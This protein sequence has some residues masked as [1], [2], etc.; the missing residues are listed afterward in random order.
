MSGFQES[1]QDQSAVQ[2]AKA[3][4]G[5]S[6]KRGAKQRPSQEEVKELFSY[7]AE[8]GILRWRKL[9]GNGKVKDGI[10][11]ELTTT[12]GIFLLV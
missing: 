1:K 3:A 11:Q 7:D 6:R 10:L 2:A 4:I 9:V 12:V 8:T 5:I